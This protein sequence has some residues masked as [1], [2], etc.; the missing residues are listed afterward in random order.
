MDPIYNDTYSKIGPKY[1]N[2]IFYEGVVT[3]VGEDLNYPFRVRVR[4]SLD[5]DNK[6]A[7]GKEVFCDPFMP[8]YYNMIPN[9]GDVVRVVL[10]YG[11]SNDEI[12]RLW[13]GP[14]RTHPIYYTN[15]NE[16]NYFNLNLPDKLRSTL[17][18]VIGGDKINKSK[19]VYANYFSHQQDKGMPYLPLDFDESSING[20]NNTDV[21]FRKQ[22]VTVRAGKFKLGKPL[23]INDTN[24]AYIDL[25]LDE[26]GNKSHINIVANKI[27]LV[28]L[29]GVINPPAIIDDSRI[30]Q[31]IEGDF[32]KLV[33]SKE[34]F[35][36]G[37]QPL[38]YGKRLVEFLEV[39]RTYVRSHKHD[40]HA[41]PA[42][43]NSDNNDGNKNA[44]LD[45]DLNSLL[46]P[47][48]K[49]N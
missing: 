30:Q 27:N 46:S 7:Y 1:K 39:L 34:S 3:S 20:K 42:R 49:T 16:V 14:L 5:R 13:I 25:F 38:V 17:V 28:A 8:I 11:A 4:I 9:T 41:Q 43:N 23:E 37:L 31:V 44:V 19:G 36:P 12:Q 48:V 15:E 32:E 40:Y 6:V 47:N 35:Q 45:F 26:E 21:L 2:R 24:P 22:R 10:P 29:E 18:N 33:Y